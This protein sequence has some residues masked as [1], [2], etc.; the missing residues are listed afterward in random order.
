RR[1]AALG[2]V[3]IGLG[4]GFLGDYGHAARR[5]DFQGKEQP[6]QAAAEDKEVKLF[7]NAASGRF[8][9]LRSTATCYGNAAAMAS[10]RFDSWQTDPLTAFAVVS[11]GAW[12][13]T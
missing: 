9:P 4:A 5:R 6:G 12:W 13:H 7:H 1:D 8:L 2:V 11:A 3:G 10:P